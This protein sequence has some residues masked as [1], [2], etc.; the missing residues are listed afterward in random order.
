MYDMYIYAQTNWNLQVSVNVCVVAR[1]RMFVV[2]RR[3][4]YRSRS[5]LTTPT[6]EEVQA[7]VGGV[8][9][10]LARDVAKRPETGRLEPSQALWTMCQTSTM[11]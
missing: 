4:R 3:Q 1:T 11:S 5:V 8:A 10:A 6:R 2:S 7:G 9:V